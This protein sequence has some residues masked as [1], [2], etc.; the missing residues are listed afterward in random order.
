MKKSITLAV[1]LSISLIFVM[2]ISVYS[3]MRVHVNDINTRFALNNTSA[4]EQI[5][6]MIHEYE[7]ET[8]Q[9]IVISVDDIYEKMNEED[10][11]YIYVGRVTCEWCRLF[12]PILNEYATK[13]NIQVFYLDSTNTDTDISLKTFREVNSIK[14]I[15][16][17]LYSK[18]G[19]NLE[20]IEFDITNE[21]FDLDL[22]ESAIL[23]M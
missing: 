4:D 13:N 6:K 20:R 19:H 16:A 21:D 11:F 7:E 15:P 22:L 3:N 1:L 2:T 14:T 23:N 5:R 12:V 17:L 9:F 18:K 8:K 10:S